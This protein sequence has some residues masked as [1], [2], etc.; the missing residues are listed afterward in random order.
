MTRK[1]EGVCLL[2]KDVLRKLTEPYGEDVIEDVF[3]EIEED[4]AW[5]RRY[6][7]LVDELT[8]PVANSFVGWHTRNLSRFET[9]RVVDAER[10]TL[11]KYYS[12]LVPK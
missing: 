2:V 12:K 5:H 8:L 9:L 1:T 4:P 7:E 3:V 6:D 10:S 11:I